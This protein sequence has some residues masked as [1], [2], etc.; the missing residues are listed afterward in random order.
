MTIEMLAEMIARQ[1]GISP[2]QIGE[3]SSITEDLGADSLDIVEMLAALEDACGICIPDEDAVNLRTVGD[4]AAY[5]SRF[6]GAEQTPP[7]WND[8]DE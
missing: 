6:D 8:N 3:D 5:V 4:V 2:E 7:D 1:M